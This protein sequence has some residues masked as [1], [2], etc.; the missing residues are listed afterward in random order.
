MALSDW[1]IPTT[2][3]IVGSGAIIIVLMC[4]IYKQRRDAR[5]GRRI[6]K[7]VAKVLGEMGCKIKGDRITCTEG[8]GIKGLGESFKLDKA[9]D[10]S[11]D[12]FCDLLRESDTPQD[13]RM[14][15]HQ[16]QQQQQQMI[17]GGF[18][19]M[20][21]SPMPS[22][23][24][25]MPGHYQQPG[26]MMPQQ[27][28]PMMPQQPGPM[29]MPP[30]QMMMMPQQPAMMP[31]PSAFGGGMDFSGNML[32]APMSP[33]MGGMMMG[34]DKKPLP[35]EPISTRDVGGGAGMAVAPT[36]SPTVY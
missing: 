26:M 5:N 25:I 35:F 36:Y 1:L 11:I 22:G 24:G 15:H 8:G 13:Q 28:G 6:R 3:V 29:M 2:G 27:P 32:G 4:I 33:M 34:D 10:R 19:D 30:P 17:P 23:A 31:Q 7:H 16:Q 12:Q 14:Q 9:V 20:P 21:R 18:Q